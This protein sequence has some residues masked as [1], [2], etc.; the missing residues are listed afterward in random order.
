MFIVPVALGALFLPRYAALLPAAIASLILL[1]IEYRLQLDHTD[2]N[3]SWAPAGLLGAFLFLVALVA[4]T[5]AIRARLDEQVAR[6]AA[7]SL[8][9][10]RQLAVQV[11]ER[12][13]AAVLVTDMQGHVLLGNAASQRLLMHRFDQRPLDQREPALWRAALQ[14]I[15]RPTLADAEPV[16]LSQGQAVWPQ[17]RRLSGDPPLLLIVVDDPDF[18]R[19]QRQQARLAAIGQITAGVAHDIRNPLAA[20]SNA[21]QL[22]EDASAEERA[23]LIG[24]LQ[25]QSQR[26]N[27][28][29]ERI[30]DLARPV[31]PQPTAVALQ[32][33]LQQ[34]RDDYL[35]SA[36]TPVAITVQAANELHCRVDPHHL[37]E[38]LDNLVDNAAQHARPAATTA[39]VVHVGAEPGDTDAETVVI[40]VVDNGE[41]PLDAGSDKPFEAFTGEGR[42]G[43][44]LTL[45][46]EL[47]EANRGYIRLCRRRKAP[48]PGTCF[49]LEF[50]RA[51][52]P[53]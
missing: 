9:Q 7:T 1:T 14:Q 2:F 16:P 19:R 29:V 53:T 44:G 6:L 45:C 34:W 32:P 36:A 30:H 51:G 13:Q 3:A 33:W 8:G 20:I 10:M 47:A 41:H 38:I 22:L 39:V 52:G 12:M 49:A 37:A 11:V 24:I 35:R 25:R 23:T 4:N 48:L 17:V 27:R 15:I 5:L 18:T 40:G 28:V 26:L 46:R 43:L 42:M 21:A 31:Q 50:P